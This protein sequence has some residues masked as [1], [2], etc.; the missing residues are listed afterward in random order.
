MLI[1]LGAEADQD[2]KNIP[3]STMIPHRS[4]N[5]TP[6]SIDIRPQY[7][8]NAGFAGRGK[9]PDSAFSG[10]DP[11]KKLRAPEGYGREI[12]H[13]IKF[14]LEGGASSTRFQKF[15]AAQYGDNADS[16]GHGS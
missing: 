10:Q 1:V 15:P 5:P 3:E 8:N 11:I 16:S 13:I 14:A 2:S 6:V 4:A 12:R 7:G 9:L